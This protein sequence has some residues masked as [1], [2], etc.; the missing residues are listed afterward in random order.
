M[1]PLRRPVEEDGRAGHLRFA[2]ALFATN[3]K[4]SLAQRGAFAM[5]VLFM[6]VNNLVFF[7]FWWALMNRVDT[8]RGWIRHPGA[9]P[10]PPVGLA[11]AVTGGA[12]PGTAHRRHELTR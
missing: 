5:Q 11:G 9:G 2:A 10:S 12:A 6:I 8:I 4:A 7:V 3:L 1:Q